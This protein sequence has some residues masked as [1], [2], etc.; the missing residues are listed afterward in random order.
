MW[1]GMIVA[2]AA[3]IAAPE[4]VLVNASFETMDG[5]LPARWN[6][7]VMPMEGAH[8][9]T[10]SAI[11]QDGTFS[12]ML[13]NPKRYEKEP[14]NNWSQNIFA[15]LAGKEVV[16]RG[17]IR[18][19]GASDAYF[20]VQSI[21]REPFAILAI[22]SSNKTTP[23]FGDMDWTAVELKTKIPPNADY[24]VVRCIL[25]GKG[26]AWFDNL[27][28]TRD[29]AVE[30]PPA[31]SPVPVTTAPAPAP[32]V[33]PDKNLAIP[34][35]PAVPDAAAIKELIAANE[36]LR[37]AATEMRRSNEALASR[38]KELQSQMLLMR[39]AMS[40]PMSSEDDEL[41]PL[42]IRSVPPIVPHGF[43]LENLR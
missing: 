33:T 41:A 8:A 14:L 24:V 26:T 18:T 28:L 9:K 12:V 20:W 17:H 34:Q 40:N 38:L 1:T 7:F 10:V 6:N 42:S 32:V 13:H 23:V 4:N 2:V 5:A 31:I 22:A 37:K 36:E 3:L 19:S 35:I 30:V 29:T 43:D 25:E 27:S 15:D 21:Q 16:L 11:A 39:G